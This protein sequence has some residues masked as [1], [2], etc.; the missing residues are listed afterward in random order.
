MM[1]V[2]AAIQE[3]LAD[4]IRTHFDGPVPD[5]ARVL[6]SPESIKVVLGRCKA[7]IDLSE[8]G[9]G[10][11]AYHFRNKIANLSLDYNIHN[12]LTRAEVDMHLTEIAR[13]TV[14]D[15]RRGKN[16]SERHAYY[17]TRSPKAGLELPTL[18]S[19]ARG[20]ELNRSNAFQ[21]AFVR[22]MYTGVRKRPQRR[23]QNLDRSGQSPPLD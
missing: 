6:S 1:N 9:P 22:D 11:L 21:R 17:W 12:A 20:A 4:F 3:N 16:Q 15:I 2:E 10:D 14:A 23:T 8:T 5:V 18:D 13:K 19:G 7:E